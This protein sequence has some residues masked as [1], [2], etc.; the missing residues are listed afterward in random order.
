M[1][2]DFEF[3]LIDGSSVVV[4]AECTEDDS[5]VVGIISPG[6]A[7]DAGRMMN[8]YIAWEAIETRAREEYAEHRARIIAERKD[9][10][11]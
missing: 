6:H 8:V 2:F 1:E 9:G 4:S 7:L 11:A 10:V 3:Q 5:L